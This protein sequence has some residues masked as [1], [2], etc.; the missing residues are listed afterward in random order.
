MNFTG[1]ETK[2]YELSYVYASDSQL[3]SERKVENVYSKIQLSYIMKNSNSQS[4]PRVREEG[5]I[6]S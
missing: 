1:D 2:K 5:A 3:N 4:K 6:T